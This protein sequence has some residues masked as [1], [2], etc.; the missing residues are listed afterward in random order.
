ML[1]VLYDDAFAKI[2]SCRHVTHKHLRWKLDTV[3]TRRTRQ[4]CLAFLR[5]KA[6]EGQAK[7]LRTS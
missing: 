4:F 6:G 3:I 7:R 2:T 1:F 5:L